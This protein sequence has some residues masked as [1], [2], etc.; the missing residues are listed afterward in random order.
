[1]HALPK[2]IAVIHY[3]IRVFAAKHSLLYSFLRSKHSLFYSFLR[4]YF[5]ITSF[6]TYTFKDVSFIH[7]LPKKKGG[8]KAKEKEW[9]FLNDLNDDA[10]NIEVGGASALLTCM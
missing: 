1:M 9:M 10:T 5:L 7:A 8:K 4:S 2:K 3:I 6:E